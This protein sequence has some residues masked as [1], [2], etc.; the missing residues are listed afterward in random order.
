MRFAIGLEGGSRIVAVV[1]IGLVGAVVLGLGVLAGFLVLDDV[2]AHVVER[3]HHVLDLFR[4]H[5]VLRQHLIELVDGDVAALLSPRDEL[6]DRAFVEIDQRRV[7]R[8][9]GVG[10]VRHVRLGHSNP[11]NLDGGNYTPP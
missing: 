3:R 1:R 7:T 5:L 9:A 2:D 10:D 11:R 8:L 4:G 6:L